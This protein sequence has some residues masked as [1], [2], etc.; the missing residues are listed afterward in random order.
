M[1]NSTHPI[2]KVTFTVL[3]L[4]FFTSKTCDSYSTSTTP[5]SSLLKEHSSQIDK[6]KSIATSWT[7]QIADSLD[8]VFFLRYCLSPNS[9]D[10]EET[11][12]LLI[13][14][15]TW[16]MLE[17]KSIVDAASA[18]IDEKIKL[19]ANVDLAIQEAIGKNFKRV[20]FWQQVMR[21]SQPSCRVRPK[22]WTA[23]ERTCSR[24]TSSWR[25]R[26]RN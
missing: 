12:T 10:E 17:G 9:S 23:C 13:N 4:L 21:W 19:M 3:T 7:P 16:R 6:L 8:D 5:V 20:A 1:I 24:Y 18:A 15:L 26:R 25:A 11:K 2:M 14:N 22:S